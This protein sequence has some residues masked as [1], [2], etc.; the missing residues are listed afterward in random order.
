[1]A[2][3]AIILVAGKNSRLSSITGNNPKC[4]LHFGERKLIDIQVDFLKKSGVERFIFVLGYQSEK[5]K[6][7][8]TKNFPGVDFVFLKNKYWSKTNVLGSLYFAQEFLSLESIILHGDILFS[9]KL[10]PKLQ[11]ART[12][13]ATLVVQKKKCGNEEMKFITSADGKKAAFLSKDINPAKADGE[14]MGIVKLSTDFGKELKK[15]LST[16]PYKSFK[17]KF[18]EWSLLQ[19]AA[20]TDLP[21]EILDVT[22]LPMIEI[23]FPKDY[24]RAKKEVFPSLPKDSLS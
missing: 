24:S 10:M 13:G 21:L 18:Y 23:D 15:I 19:V 11:K 4:L 17:D 22:N 7:H 8:L 3:Q 20:T 1:M 16:F 6:K 2:K 14:F 5:I 9:P 12:M